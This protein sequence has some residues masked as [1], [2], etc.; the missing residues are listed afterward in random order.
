MKLQ[1]G[2]TLIELMTT[3]AVAGMLASLAV[4]AMSGFSSNARQTSTINDLVSS[5]H[6]ARSAAIS[7]NNRVTVCASSSGNN[8]E[9]TGWNSG[10]IV[11]HDVDSDQSVDAGE[12][13][14]GVHSGEAK[15]NLAS[16]G[17][18]Q[19]MTYRPNG[20]VVNAAA[21]DFIVCDDRG[22]SHAKVLIV[23]LSGRP[24]TSEKRADGSAPSCP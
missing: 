24:R 12:T 5:M 1:R 23:D 19:A 13:V 18:P 9:V 2:F 16:A 4:P 14:L 20:R 8:C 3:L 22:A 10:W 7:T 11:F 15:L 6:V 21:G 17:F